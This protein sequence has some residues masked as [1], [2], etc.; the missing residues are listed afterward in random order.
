MPI[1]LRLTTPG[2]D[3]CGY[4]SISAHNRAPGARPARAA[5]VINPGTGPVDTG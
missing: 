5:G 4:R 2:H 3:S 1:P